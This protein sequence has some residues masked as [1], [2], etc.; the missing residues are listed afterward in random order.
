VVQPAEPESARRRLQVGINP[1]PFCDER[2]WP[3]D[4]RELYQKYV[5]KLADF[6]LWLNERGHS[7]LFFPTQ[8]RADP[9]VIRDIQ[10]LLRGH[11]AVSL[12]DPL[13]DRPLRS[14]DD[15]IVTI[16]TMDIV[17]A[18]RYHGVLLSALLHR[19]VLAVAYLE[20][21]R[22]LMAQIGQ[23]DYVVDIK[24]FDTKSLAQRFVVMESKSKTIRSEIERR[25]KTLR[26]TL[27][28]EYGRVFGL[29][30]DHRG[31]GAAD[32]GVAALTRLNGVTG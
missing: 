16:S 10:A 29:L 20:K 7:V 5:R 23:S 30:E 15:L 22:D 19:P 1:L 25:T 6:A 9:P 18:T 14:L 32:E 4:N 2:Y 26:Q 8:L 31:A 12:E 13:R 17:V 24:S 27:R 11:G 3:E 28:S 21:T